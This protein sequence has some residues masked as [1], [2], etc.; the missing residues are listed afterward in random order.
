M[1]HAQ[2]QPSPGRP[3]LGLLFLI[4]LGNNWAGITDAY[5]A[6]TNWAGKEIAHAILPGPSGT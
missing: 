6:L 4:A 3:F 5:F 1:A 2:A